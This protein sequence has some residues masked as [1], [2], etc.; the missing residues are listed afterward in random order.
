VTE[1]L[2]GAILR[3]LMAVQDEQAERLR[4]IE[5]NVQRLIDRPLQTAK[6]HLREAALPRRRREDVIRSLDRAALDLRDAVQGLPDRTRSRAYVTFDLAVVLLML[7]DRDASRMYAGEALHAM[8][9]VLVKVA[10]DE[11][12][13]VAG[14]PDGRSFQDPKRLQKYRP[15]KSVRP[16]IALDWLNLACAVAELTRDRD[17]VRTERTR[18]LDGSLGALELQAIG[19]SSARDRLQAITTAPLDYG[20]WSLPA[21]VHSWKPDELPKLPEWWPVEGHYQPDLFSDRHESGHFLSKDKL[22]L[23][24]PWPYEDLPPPPWWG[25]LDGT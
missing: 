16:A 23:I 14:R 6:M 13:K 22:S 15:E 25:K 10:T 19:T 24:R 4:R 17:I 8:T 3:D 21:A 11:F 2:L 7:A 5:A 12:F 9:D 1:E 18:I 20:L